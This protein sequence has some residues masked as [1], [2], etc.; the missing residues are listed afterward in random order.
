VSELVASF[1][2][3]GVI[4][5]GGRDVVAG[6]L[7]PGDLVAF[8]VALAAMNQPLKGLSEMGAL[9]QRSLAA[10]ERVFALLDTRSAIVDGGTSVAG[11]PS[12]IELV[13]VAVDYGE[14][15]VV[16]GVNLTIEA[17]QRVAL[18]GASGSGKTSLLGLLPRLFDPAVGE[19]RWDGVD[20]RAYRLASLR[21]QIAVVS[22]E[23]FLFDETVAANI[24][25]GRPEAS[26]AEVE[27][28][29]VAANAHAFITA[30]PKG[31][32]TRIDELGMRL[33]GGQRQRICIARAILRGAPVLLLDEA[34]SNLDAESEAAVQDALDRLMVG[35]TTIVVAHRLSTVRDADLIVVLSAGRVVERGR[36]EELLLA[37]GEYA[38]LVARQG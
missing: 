37:G 22:Q 34:T 33:S 16:A 31:Y 2:V 32:A 7:A 30:L 1:G 9:L 17:G 36:H 5:V 29:A 23:T 6:T 19:V 10:A 13:D 4:F 15:P 20:L 28:A 27:A 11:P 24:R 38:R 3:G 26:D 35:R 14:G 8:L 18:V 25:F 12:R 21:R